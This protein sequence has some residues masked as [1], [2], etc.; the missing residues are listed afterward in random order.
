LLL[1]NE[2]SGRRELVIMSDVTISDDVRD[3]YPGVK[4][5][6]L[7]ATGIRVRPCPNRLRKV[8]RAVE[9]ELRRKHTP[10]SIFQD[11]VIASWVEIYDLMGI[12]KE[13][14]LPAQLDLSLKVLSGERIPRINNL[15][16]IA[17]TVSVAHRCPVGAFDGDTLVGSAVLRLSSDGETYVPIFAEKPERIPAGEIVYADE[18]GVFS[19]YSKD[20]DRTKILEDTRTALYVVDGAPDTPKDVLARALS[21][22]AALVRGCGEDVAIEE[23]YVEG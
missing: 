5:A 7:W 20:A 1:G 10:E 6:F 21:D 13:I 17:N 16:Y 22:I 9:D 8:G 15:V 4:V 18:K 2:S 19:R 12:D 3:L 23:G 14:L 11:P